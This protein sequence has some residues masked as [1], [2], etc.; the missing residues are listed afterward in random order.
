MEN[1]S[2]KQPANDN[3]AARNQ[4]A[5]IIVGVSLVGVFLLGAVIIVAAPAA[6]ASERAQLVFNAVLPLIGAWVGTVLAFFFARENF[7]SATN[8]AI[9]IASTSY[10]AQ[11]DWRSI[12]VKTAMTRRSKMYVCDDLTK[13]IAEIV[14]DL[15]ARDVSRLPVLD[16]AGVALA[17]FYIEDI[18][19]V[20]DKQNDPNLTMQ[21]LMDYGKSTEPAILK[22]YTFVSENS[23]LADA[24]SKMGQTPNCRD[25]FVTSSGTPT[26]EV[27]GI[28]TNVDIDRFTRG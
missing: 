25:V 7:D 1:Q 19:R 24:K 12:N 17:L 10:A 3:T 27:L 8:N 16:Q 22:K 13:K 18:Y 26:E 28:L 2:D 23:T 6:Q 21:G 20:R 5:L 9:K 15:E 14:P 11:E 4:L